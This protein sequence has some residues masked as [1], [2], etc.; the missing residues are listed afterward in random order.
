MDIIIK[1]TETKEVNISELERQRDDYLAMA[2]DVK[3]IEIRE[4]LPDYAEELVVEKNLE[5][6]LQ[7]ADM[8][9]QARLIDEEIASYG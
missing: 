2:E 4:Y 6:E 3:L 9:E 8:I 7:K 1:I 5:L